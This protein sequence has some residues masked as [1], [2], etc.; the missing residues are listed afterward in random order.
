MPPTEEPPNLTGSVD[1]WNKIIEKAVDMY[2]RAASFF[3]DDEPEKQ[4]LLE[5]DCRLR[6]IVGVYI[7][8][9][10]DSREYSRTRTFQA[11]T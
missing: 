3:L 5:N 2:L 9:L 1:Q 11:M 10:A 4:V 7:H 6:T 8:D